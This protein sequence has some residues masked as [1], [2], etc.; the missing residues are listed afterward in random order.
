MLRLLVAAGFLILAS[1]AEAS[2]AVATTTAN[3][4]LPNSAITFV[5]TDTG[6]AARATFAAG[7]SN[8]A[9]F[10]WTNNFPEFV[11]TGLQ[12]L[13]VTFSAPTRLD[14]FVLGV[15]SI[16]VGPVFTLTVAGG[17]ATTADFTLTDG[18]NAVANNGPATYDG[19]TGEFTATARD[20]GLMISSTS[21]ATI[22]SFSLTG[23]DGGDGFTF[24]F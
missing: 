1:R 19:A 7:S 9:V 17:T 2:I 10:S 5:I 6:G 8:N 11:A 16:V 23:N 20:Q 18:I 13:T 22:T 24:F 4:T 14:Q 12:T 3:G 15:S 21:F